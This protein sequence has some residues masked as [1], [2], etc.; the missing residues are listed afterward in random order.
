MKLDKIRD[1]LINF[2]QKDWKKAE[3]ETGLHFAQMKY[4]MSAL[5]KGDD[6]YQFKVMKGETS[7]P[8]Y[9]VN[10]RADIPADFFRSVDKESSMTVPIGGKKYPVRGCNDGMWDYLVNSPIEFPTIEYPICNFQETFV[11]FEPKTIQY[12][13]WTYYASPAEP[14]FG[15]KYNRGFTEY[16]PTTSTELN[17]SEDQI[18]YIIQIM[19]QDLGVM[20]TVEQI[21]EKANAS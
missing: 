4:F 7:P 9:V 15:V 13:N 21:K 6:L 5:D 14:V 10:G 8:L 1:I 19:L 16:D 11:R 2:I 20:A 17:W 12:V 3:F 18:V